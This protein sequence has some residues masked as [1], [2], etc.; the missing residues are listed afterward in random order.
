[1]SDYH[2]IYT[3]WRCG[4]T[5]DKKRLCHKCIKEFSDMIDGDYDNE[6][7]ELKSRGYVK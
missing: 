4:K 3:C 2:F 1:M 5:A 7:E 6:K